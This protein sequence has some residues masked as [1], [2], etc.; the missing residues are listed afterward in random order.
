VQNPEPIILSWSGGKDSAL[1]LAALQDD[2]AFHVVALLT[3]VTTGYDRI[4]VHGVRRALLA[5]QERAIGLPVH[6][7]VI[8]PQSSNA[9][10]DAAVE[11]ALGDVRRRY[12][13]VRR[14]A[15][16]DLFLEDVRRYREERLAPLGFE[17]CFP[18]WGRP[19]AALARE[20]I[21]RGFEARLVCVD[22]TQLEA[23][24]AGR[25]FDA[26][27]LDEMPPSVD[28]CGERGEFHT[29]VSAGPGFAEQVEYEVGEIVLRDGRF[30][31][32]DLVER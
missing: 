24:F 6:E 30:A 1:A 29:F 20:F 2:P 11:H 16:G 19:T 17:G 8:E 4:S 15:Y 18:L 12:P 14:I 5:A 13:D 25:A 10:Y 7:I 9:A 26:A 22:T 23:A 3:T 32:C 28:P 31:F 21:E 27:L